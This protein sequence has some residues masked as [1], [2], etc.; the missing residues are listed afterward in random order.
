MVLLVAFRLPPTLSIDCRESV[1]ICTR[2]QDAVGMQG[3]ASDAPRVTRGESE[4][5]ALSECPASG[6]FCVN[7]GPCKETKRQL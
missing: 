7:N 1:A 3:L 4:Q 2:I 6:D 5:M